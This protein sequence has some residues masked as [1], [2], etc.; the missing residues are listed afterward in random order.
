M[1]LLLLLQHELRQRRQALEQH[2]VD[3]VAGVAVGSGRSCRCSAWVLLWL[4]SNQIT[5]GTTTTA[6]T[7]V[8]VLRANALVRSCLAE[9]WLWLL[10]LLLLLLLLLLHGCAA[11]DILVLCVSVSSQ[12]LLLLLLRKLELHLLLLLHQVHHV[13]LHNKL[14]LVGHFCGTLS[15]IY[16]AQHWDFFLKIL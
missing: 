7:T 1:L 11:R 16:S 9:I 10:Q 3:Q 13:E 8:G 6:T 15:R 14:H 4:K 2:L 12:L 5:I